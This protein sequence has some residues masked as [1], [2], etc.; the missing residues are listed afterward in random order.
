MATTS[1]ET[2]KLAISAAI[3]RVWKWPSRHPV[4]S[5]FS[6]VALSIYGL[7]AMVGTMKDI[8][9]FSIWL[10]SQW[11]S[12]VLFSTSP[13][14]RWLTPVFLASSI[15]ASI[16]FVAKREERSQRIAADE[17][18]KYVTKT[19]LPLLQINVALADSM[20][21]AER[22]SAASVYL[23]NIDI[24]E[25][26]QSRSVLE[27]IR[28]QNEGDKK[29]CK[30]DLL[31]FQRNLVERHMVFSR[32]AGLFGGNDIPTSMHPAGSLRRVFSNLPGDFEVAEDQDLAIILE[33]YYNLISYLR[34]ELRNYIESQTALVAMSRDEIVEIAHQTNE[35][36][37][38][39]IQLRPN[40]AIKTQP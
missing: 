16:N 11:D 8:A 36:I 39:Q 12:L 20:M 33:K 22:I 5:I 26:S 29:K 40:T 2:A 32:K 7:A 30:S 27:Y 25:D 13:V 38:N 18:L 24:E 19:I 17:H 28:L 14:F 31:F 3:S 10:G 9:D 6:G 21:A 4:F 37:Q 23:M 35:A 1:T 15:F 34:D